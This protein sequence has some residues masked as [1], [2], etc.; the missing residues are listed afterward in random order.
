MKTAW[1]IFS[2]LEHQK[3]FQQIVIPCVMVWKDSE[4]AEGIVVA[5]NRVVNMIMRQDAVPVRVVDIEHRVDMLRQMI[6]IDVTVSCLIQKRRVARRFK[7]PAK[8]IIFRARRMSDFSIRYPQQVV[9]YIRENI[10][11][12]TIAY[13]YEGG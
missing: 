4:L 7:P 12:N 6:V 9:D 10:G 13:E 3:V 2:H 5:T 1:Q 8:W 11:I